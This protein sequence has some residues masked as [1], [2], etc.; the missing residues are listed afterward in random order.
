MF[1]SNA[2]TA[3]SISTLRAQSS[4]YGVVLPT[5]RGTNRV[6]AKMIDWTDFTAIGQQQSVGGKGGGGN[7][8]NYI[9]QAAVDLALAMTQGCVRIGMIWDGQG[10]YGNG[11]MIE[12]ITIP[13]GVPGS[14]TPVGATDEDYLADVGVSLITTEEVW[15]PAYDPTSGLPQ[16]GGAPGVGDGYYETQNVYTPMTRVG[17]SN[18]GQG[19]YSITGSGTSLAYLFNSADAG[20]DAKL[21]YALSVN[22]AQEF[23]F[24]PGSRPQSPWAYMLGRYPSRALAYAGTCHVAA[25][26]FQLGSSGTLDNLN[27]ELVGP[28]VF[29]GG[30]QDAGIDQCIHLVT[31]DPDGGCGFPTALIGDLTAAIAYCASAGIFFSPI[32]DR[33]QTAASYLQDYCDAANLAVCWNDGFLK[34]IPY[35]DTPLAGNGFTYVPDLTPIYDLDDDDFQAEDDEPPLKI[36][37]E[38]PETLTNIIEIDILDRALSY[39]THPIKDRDSALIFRFGPIPASARK[40]DFICDVNVGAIVANH[41]RLRT[42]Q[43][44]VLSITFKLGSQYELLEKMDIVTITCL[45][46]GWVKKPFRL[47]ESDEDPET[48]ETEWTAEPVMWG[49]CNA[50]LYPKQPPGGG[51][52]QRDAAPG[53]IL[54]PI[55]F[56]APDPLM[57]QGQYQLWLGLCGALNLLNNPGFE[58][59]PAP[60]SGDIADGW[61]GQSVAPGFYV[62]IETGIGESYSGESDLYISPCHRGAPLVVAANSTSYAAIFSRTTFPVS[63]GQRYLMSCWANIQASDPLNGISALAFL[64]GRINFSDGSYQDFSSNVLTGAA[65]GTGWQQLN[66]TFTVPAAPAGKTITGMNVFVWVQLVNGT[67]APITLNGCPFDVRVD[68]AMLALLSAED[69]TWGGCH[70]YASSDGNTYKQVGQQSGP[71]RMGVLL[72]DFPALSPA[73]AGLDAA[74]TLSVDLSE[75]GGMMLSGTAADR[76]SFRTLCWVEG[77]NGLYELIS[78]MTATLVSGNQYQ[79]TSLQRGVYG[80]PVLDHPAGMRFLRCDD[81][82]TKLTFSASDV[83]QAAYFK[84]TSF[85]QYGLAEEALSAVTEYQYGL[86]G[87]F[88]NSGQIVANDGTVDYDSTTLSSS[89]VTIRAYGTAAGVPTPGDPINFK[90]QDGSTF[91]CTALSQAGSSLTTT[92]YAVLNRLADAPYWLTSYSAVL[93]AI[94]NGHVLIGSVTTPAAGGSGGTTGGGGGT[95]GGGGGLPPGGCFSGNV[96]IKLIDMFQRFD[97]LPSFVYIENETGIH[98]AELLI[99]DHDGP[100]IDFTGNGELVTPEHLIKDG[101]KWTPAALFYKDCKIVRFTGKVYNLHVLSENPEDRHYGLCNGDIA[102]NEKMIPQ[103]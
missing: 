91:A 16:S 41:I 53:S 59:A 37:R 2:K 26:A 48:G 39:N 62:G 90:K 21:V 64:D 66:G 30:I 72:A 14:Y 35:G 9:Y 60:G 31:D 99:H 103:L 23:T 82:I 58:N 81:A 68:C 32:C 11:Q 65:I 93:S 46:A 87:L 19:Q 57:P 18:P 84:A 34:F 85:N 56:E 3:P 96:P 74:N 25:E 63:S 45:E 12:Q 5:I 50:T 77:A 33:Q 92:F 75:S 89:G 36:E 43:I 71:S 78:Y 29:G 10:E 40:Y 1:G 55:I 27:F 76:D 42:T 28:G 7:I 4:V 86:Q 97:E 80:T 54:P 38:D 6:P 69:T 83:D 47:K 8:T 17:G 67:G 70:L 94:G 98:L 101:M 44:D 102:H 61:Y 24:F 15:V 49:S 51:S 88:N 22:I 100:M 52:T 73:V 20:K 13:A 95:S 79:L